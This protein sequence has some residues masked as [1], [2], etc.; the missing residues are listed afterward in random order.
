MI[1]WDP[2]RKAVSL[3]DSHNTSEPFFLYLAYQSPHMDLELAP[4]RYQVPFKVRTILQYQP[5]TSTMI[6]KYIKT[7][8]EMICRPEGGQGQYP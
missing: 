7:V 6:R 2:Y 1:K 5:R 3:I 4:A 8:W